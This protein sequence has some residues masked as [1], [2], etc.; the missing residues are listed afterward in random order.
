MVPPARRRATFDDVLGAPDHVVAE[1][2]DGALHLSPR[3]AKAQSWARCG[4]TSR[5]RP[6]PAEPDDRGARSR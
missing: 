5:S 3:S 6:T 4:P 2:V 1:I